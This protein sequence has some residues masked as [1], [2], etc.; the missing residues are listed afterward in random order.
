MPHFVQ[1][2]VIS[3]FEFVTAHKREL[4]GVTKLE[5]VNDLNI[6]DFALS[7]SE[8]VVSSKAKPDH[9]GQ[10][11][12]FGSGGVL[13]GDNGIIYN[14]EKAT[15]TVSKL[16]VTDFVAPALNFNGGVITSASLVNV[17]IENLK[18]LIVDQLAIKSEATENRDESRFKMAIVDNRG[19][20][21]STNGIIWDKEKKQLLLPRI[22]S[23]TKSGISIE[24]DIDLNFHTMRNSIIEEGTILKKLQFEDGTISNSILNNVTAKNLKLGDVEVE[25]I[26]VSTLSKV[27]NT[28][29]VLTV[30]EQGKLIT[31][32]MFLEH[33][34][35]LQ[36]TKPVQFKESIDLEYNNILNAEITGGS[37]KGGDV[38]IDVKSV[39]AD[40]VSLSEKSDDLNNKENLVVIGRNG[41]FK[42]G[43]I[44]LGKNGMIES[45][46]ADEL[47]VNGKAMFQSGAQINGDTYIDGSLTVS[48][49]VLVSN[50]GEIV[51]FILL[52]NFL[53]VAGFWTLCRCFRFQVQKGDC[54]P[55]II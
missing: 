42:R 35:N 29:A 22:S 37:V 25:S 8:L 13:K 39:L 50:T 23:N 12:F 48:A 33:D 28:G 44:S 27:E 2:N 19:I 17:T 9:L 38:V 16:S 43:S 15:L 52:L 4:S 53:S 34:G 51:L 10:V 7:S 24:S 45:L 5:A 18:H 20:I 1:L 36:I 41:N 47:E 6:G 21:S 30:G 55:T 11:I 49:S 14:P 3:C 40:S 31:S 32:D 26:S 46:K 54:T